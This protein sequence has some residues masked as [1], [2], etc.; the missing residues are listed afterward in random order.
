MRI[1]SIIEKLPKIIKRGKLEAEEILDRPFEKLDIPKEIIISNLNKKNTYKNK[2]INEFY[3]GDNLIVIEKLLKEGYIDNIDLIYIDPPFLT[4]ANYKG[5]ITLKNGQKDEVIECFAY[6]DTWENGLESYLKMLC[7]RLYLMKELLSSKGTI[8]VHLDYRTVH[9][10][11]IMMDEIFGQQNFINEVIWAYKSGGVSKRYYSRKHD[12][13]LVYSKT[14]DYIFNPQLEKSYNR[15]FKPYRFKGV[16]EFEDHIGWYT[17]VNLKDVWNIDMVGRTSKERVGYDTQKPEK[18]LERIILTSSNE[19][20][21]VADFFAGSGTTGIVGE[22]YNRKWIMA[23][24]GTLSA[25]TINKRLIEKNSLPYKIYK[26]DEFSTGANKLFIKNI[27]IRKDK[28]E[29]NIELDK[30]EIDIN[31]LYIKEKYKNKIEEILL[32][33]SL[34]LIDFIGI[35]I[36]YDGNI[37]IITWQ[38]YRKDTKLNI[39]S[40]IKIKDKN[41]KNSKGIFIKCID[42]F[43]FQYETILEI[44]DERVAIC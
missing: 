33:E 10:V 22:K 40:K 13:I 8:Y 15:D 7:I 1:L 20:S 26:I 27:E 12:T 35:D 23:D 16:E 11:K 9:Y 34:N 14:K 41:L 3:Q 24:K 39:D 2:C 42:V 32:K 18:L 28:G 36:D 5:K 17:L 44:N 21:I 30:Y 29:L 43:G 25:A 37:P 4:N 31:K 19:G 6:K 38:D